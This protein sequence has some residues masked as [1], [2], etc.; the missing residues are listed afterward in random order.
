VAYT[1]THDNNTTRGWFEEE[2]TEKDKKRLFDYCG[3]AF[4]AERAPW[5]M[6]RLAQASVA[7]LCLFPMQDLLCL[8]SEAR[9]NIPAVSN[10][11]WEWR[12]DAGLLNDGVK[13]QLRSLTKLFGRG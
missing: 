11:N 6:I 10:G 1:G 4:T 5:E 13:E 2:A 8:G 7:E 9:M 3:H 12:L